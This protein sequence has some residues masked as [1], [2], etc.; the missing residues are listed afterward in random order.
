MFSVSL[1]IIFNIIITIMGV[2]SVMNGVIDITAGATT[3]ARAMALAKGKLAFVFG[4]VPTNLII[5]LQMI[6]NTIIIIIYSSS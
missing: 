3:M 4:P 2:V 1:I 6:I 5:I